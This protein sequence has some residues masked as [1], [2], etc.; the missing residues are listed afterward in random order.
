[1]KLLLALALLSMTSLTFAKRLETLEDYDASRSYVVHWA[2]VVF[3]NVSVPVKN[4][5]VDGSNLKTISPATY[6]SESAVVEV[7]TRTN[8]SEECRPVRKGETPKQSPNTRL[9]W[10][11]VAHASQNFET[12]VAYQADVCVKWERNEN[13]NH[14]QA[15]YKCVEMGKVT[16]DYPLSYDVSV[17]SNNSSNHGSTVE[18]ANIRFDLPVCK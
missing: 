7:C 17:T 14:G 9:V 1:M 5:C 6:C 18:V 4:V 10:G 13:T 8:H 11:C 3:S 12:T 15:T 16:K 2:S